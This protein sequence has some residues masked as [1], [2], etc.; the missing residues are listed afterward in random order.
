M[1]KNGS[2]SVAHNMNLHSES[3]MHTSCI[4][5]HTS[6]MNKRATLVKHIIHTNTHTHKLNAKNTLFYDNNIIIMRMFCVVLL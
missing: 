2:K 6:A 1:A 3:D 4:R 5:T